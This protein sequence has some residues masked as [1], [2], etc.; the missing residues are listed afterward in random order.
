MTNWTPIRETLYER[1]R[2]RCEIS[3]LALG[4]SWAAHHRRKRGS[5]GTSL[6]DAHSLPNLLALSHQAHNLR[7]PSAH[8]DVA[9]AAARGY[10]IPWW[11][12]PRLAPVWLLGRKWVLLTEGGAYLPLPLDVM[13]PPVG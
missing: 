13:Q 6:A 8:L 9:W 5:G 10:T 4:D 7:R 1:A 3:G 12:V 2:G 11:E